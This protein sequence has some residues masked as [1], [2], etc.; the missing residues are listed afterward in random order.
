M[1]LGDFNRRFV[2]F[3]TDLIPPL[4]VKGINTAHFHLGNLRFLR[5]C[6]IG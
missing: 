4:G 6:C 3:G 5:Q 1:C 2:M